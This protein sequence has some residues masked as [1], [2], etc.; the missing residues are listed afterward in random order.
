MVFQ[1]DKGELDTHVRCS[2]ADLVLNG[3][4]ERRCSLISLIRDSAPR[5]GP[6]VQETMH[7]GVFRL[8]T[9]L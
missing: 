9:T 1:F 8:Q 7:T 5:Y 4:K 6:G 3:E 2:L